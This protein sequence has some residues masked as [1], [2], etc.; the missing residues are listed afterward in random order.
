M[1]HLEY[2]GHDLTPNG[3]CPATSKFNLIQDWPLPTNGLNLHSFLGLCSF[4]NQYIAL[5]SKLRLPHCRQSSALTN[6]TPSLQ[7]NGW[8]PTKLS[9]TTL[10]RASPPHL[11]LPIMM[12]TAHATDCSASGMGYILMQPNTAAAKC[13]LLSFCS[14][15]A[16]SKFNTSITGPRLCPILFGLHRFTPK[17]RHFHSFIGE[18]ACS[19]WAIGQLWKYV[20]GTHFYWIT[21]CITLHEF[22]D[23]DGPIHQACCWTW[24]LLGYYFTVLH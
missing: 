21:N 2:V 12:P 8:T 9:F 4:Y 24:E 22:I 13:N 19:H 20:W 14:D 15:H 5:G 7:L 18:A 11:A 6:A 17:E 1:D 3:S 16:A 23:Y 10:S